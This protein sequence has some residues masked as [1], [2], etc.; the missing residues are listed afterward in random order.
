MK[1]LRGLLCASLL[2]ASG[3]ARRIKSLSRDLAAKSRN[4]GKLERS[5]AEATVDINPFE[6]D[7]PVLD[8]YQRACLMERAS[9]FSDVHERL[10][11]D[12]PIW[13]DERN[14]STVAEEVITLERKDRS[15][16]GP[17]L[18]KLVEEI[19]SLED[20]KEHREAGR[21]KLQAWFHWD[22]W[23]S[24]VTEWD[25]K[26]QQK[27][28]EALGLGFSYEGA[29]E[30]C[31]KGYDTHCYNCMMINAP[32]R[33]GS[34]MDPRVA[35]H[36]P[37]ACQDK[38]KRRLDI[39]DIMA[40]P[41]SDERSAALWKEAEE[42]KSSLK[43]QGYDWYNQKWYCKKAMERQADEVK[44]RT[45][46][47]LKAARSHDNGDGT[48]AEVSNM[49]CPPG[50][51]ATTQ[52]ARDAAKTAA[53][54]TGTYIFGKV[55]ITPA[56]ALAGAAMAADFALTAGTGTIIGTLAGGCVGSWLSLAAGYFAG[57]GP[58]ECACFPRTCGFDNITK[59]CAMVS[60]DESPTKNPYAK[61]LPIAGSKCVLE[62]KSENQCINTH[63]DDPDFKDTH[64]SFPKLN[65]EGFLL[66]RI[67]GKIGRH[68]K[69]TFN[70]LSTNGDSTGSLMFS[71]TIHYAPNTVEER[72]KLYSKIIN[73]S[74]RPM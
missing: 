23:S 53:A 25:S 52:R 70:C 74:A 28:E 44:K 50:T 55:V 21:N 30:R 27:K 60:E 12:M 67:F 73:S 26:I 47:E 48:C 49:T 62:Y 39:R 54:F 24:K 8:I 42:I 9:D 22:S 37:S 51:Y 46:S 19:I 43:L 72:L 36:S 64:A 40:H 15:Q 38:I 14:G 65:S 63:C 66:P 45:V 6:V 41:M 33:A 3:D 7:N 1:C 10:G 59:S 18:R 68:G 16:I 13:K 58:L 57:L 20:L 32:T 11:I 34:L 31:D 56:L 5:D 29:K 61:L 71:D 17:H 69:E 35:C 4:D 2:L